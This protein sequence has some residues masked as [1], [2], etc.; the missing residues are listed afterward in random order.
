MNPIIVTWAKIEARRVVK[1]ELQKKG[2]KIAYVPRRKIDEAADLYLQ[3]HPELFDQAA[4][5]VRNSPSLHAM[6]QREE[7]HR[8]KRAKVR[9]GAKKRGV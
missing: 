4:E 8:Q 3:A 5:T 2:E 7:L 6:A 9:S 1:R